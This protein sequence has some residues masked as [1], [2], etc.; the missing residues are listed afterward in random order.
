MKQENSSRYTVQVLAKALAVLETLAQHG[1]L[2]LA[3]LAQAVDQPKSSVFR[4]LVTLEERG[5]IRRHP[6]TEQYSLGVKL[7]SLGNLVTGQFNVHEEAIGF[8]RQLLDKFR[9]TVNL[10]ILEDGQIVYL[11]ILEGTQSVRMA[12]RPGQRDFAHS[13]AIGK[14]ILSHLP[15]EDLTAILKRHGLPA[16]TE[17]TITN[18]EAL[19]VELQR[20]RERGYA[21]DNLENEPG[22]RCVGAPIFNHHAEVIAAISVSGPASRITPSQVE[23]IG[24]ELIAATRAISERL[25]YRGQ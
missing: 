2:S 15:H 4:Y 9:E 25:G 19:Q 17:A 1:A 20:V 5:Y 12:A 11:D 10:A 21:I 8:M 22:V 16:M 24:R 13:T 6:A 14:S 18:L 3:E 7:I 23:M